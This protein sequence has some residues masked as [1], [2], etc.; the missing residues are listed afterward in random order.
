[1]INVYAPNDANARNEYYQQPSTLNLPQHGLLS[2]D[3]D[4]NCTTHPV[5]SS[6]ARDGHHHGLY[7]L[8][9]AWKV[10]DVLEGQI[11]RFETQE[12]ILEHQ[13]L[14]HIYYYKTGSGER[15]SSRRDS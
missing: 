1:M 3:G 8:M 6:R 15:W 5:D 7:Q 10:T 11:E 9:A 13:T 2:V 14:Y 12:Q 4:F